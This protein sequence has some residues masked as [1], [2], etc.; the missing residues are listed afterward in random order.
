MEKI[1]EKKDGGD[2]ESWSEHDWSWWHDISNNSLS[3]LTW[4]K[5]W[6]LHMK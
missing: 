2:R 1:F 3:F 6:T 5:I 4:I